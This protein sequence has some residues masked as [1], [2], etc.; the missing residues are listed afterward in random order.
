MRILLFALIALC[1]LVNLKAA[2]KYP[3]EERLR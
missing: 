3:I 2:D 1:S